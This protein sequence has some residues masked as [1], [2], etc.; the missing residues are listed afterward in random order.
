M[1][2]AAVRGAALPA[3]A[4]ALVAAAL[5]AGRGSSD[6]RL[7]WIG[8]SCVVL[9]ATAAILVP[10]VVSGEAFA[11][12]ACLAGFAVWQAVT[13][14]WSVQPARSWDYANRGLVYF[15]F[16]S[17]GLLLAGLPRR[18]IATAVGML[19]TL[20]LAVA[21]IG[22]IFPGIEAD[23]ARLA[24][25]R[26]PLGYWNE[27]A[28][29]A[30]LTVPLGLFL[31]GRRDRPLRA[32]VAGALHVYAAFVAVVLTFSRFGI[33]L[34]LAAAAVWVWLD[35][36]R[37]DSLVALACSVPV[38]AVVAGVGLALPGIADDHQTHATRV[39]D[40]W[41]FALVLVGGGVAIAAAHQRPCELVTSFEIVRVGG[42][43]P[44][45]LAHIARGR[46]LGERQ[47]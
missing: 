37:L 12:L 44:F 31:A 20:T 47:R 8:A 22:K 29:V 27:L 14:Q 28:L 38:A 9:V 43:S 21:F 6:S 5:L 24:R 1:R 46:S 30:A 39:H 4:A 10:P 42:D 13:I 36:E 26:W 34:A 18:W 35:R 25:L 19:F 23:Y 45:E 15:A 33:V 3:A 16:A 40:G 41:I 7:F 17:L 2:R 11:L 32:R